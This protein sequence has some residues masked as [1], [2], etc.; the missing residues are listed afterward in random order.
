AMTKNNVWNFNYNYGSNSRKNSGIGTFTLS[1][2]ASDTTGNNYEVQIRETAIISP[3][4]VHEARFQIEHSTSN[5]LSRSLGVSVNVSDAFN[6]GGGNSNS[7]S[8]DTT[9]EVGNLILFNTPKWTL[10]AGLQLD[11]INNH[12]VN[13]G[14][15]SGTY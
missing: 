11:T 13:A 3:T 14:N 15:F 9:Y 1:N 2:R 6:G 12:S 8:D 4:L 10:K 5:Q 7:S